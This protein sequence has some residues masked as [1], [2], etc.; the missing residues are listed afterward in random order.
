M[1]KKL[2]NTGM[3]KYSMDVSLI[4]PSEYFMLNILVKAHLLFVTFAAGF[5]LNVSV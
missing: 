4:P 5:L 1:T 3:L 2:Y